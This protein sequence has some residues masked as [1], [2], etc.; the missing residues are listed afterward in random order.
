MEIQ[1]THVDFCVA[2][3]VGVKIGPVYDVDD[4]K[5]IIQKLNPRNEPGR[6]SLI[7]RFGAEK[8]SALLPP[9]LRAIKMEG[10]N[11]VW[12]CD[13]MHGNTYTYGRM[14][15]TRK[16]EDILKE[17]REFWQIHRSE[18]SIAGGV[19]LELTGDN[20]T[21]CV[22]GKR[23]LLEKDLHLNYLTNCDPRLNAEQAV[24]LAFEIAAIFNL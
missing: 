15:K 12:I 10:F 5:G 24:E 19:H 14:H 7:T 8:I 1:K 6:L 22:G 20:V 23:R 11:I 4:I 16:Y 21:E 3:P 17:I 2:N 18:G 13:P 9:L